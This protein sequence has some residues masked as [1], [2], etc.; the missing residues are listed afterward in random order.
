MEKD[1][2]LSEALGYTNYLHTIQKQFPLSTDY[3]PTHYPE[4][5]EKYSIWIDQLS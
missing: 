5:F 1:I 4:T 2:E 3:Q